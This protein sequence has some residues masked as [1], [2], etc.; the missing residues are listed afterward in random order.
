MMKR[1]FR[2]MAASGQC[3]EIIYYLTLVQLYELMYRIPLAVGGL[4]VCCLMPPQRHVFRYQHHRSSAT[5]AASLTHV[6]F[7]IR[8]ASQCS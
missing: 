7:L 1:Y 5:T 4:S 2:D 8:L 6:L 3:L